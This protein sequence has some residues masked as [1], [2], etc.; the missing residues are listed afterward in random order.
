MI[1]E[2]AKIMGF[3]DK[4]IQNNF[5]RAFNFIEIQEYG[6]KQYAQYGLINYVKIEWFVRIKKIVII[7]IIKDK[8]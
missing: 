1:K 2:K 8:S 7:Q 3:C 6:L 4:S 5:V